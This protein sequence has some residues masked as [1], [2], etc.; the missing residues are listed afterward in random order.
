MTAK[1]NR[2]FSLVEMLVVM[3][4]IVLALGMGV[5]AFKALSGGR[6]LEAASNNVAAALGQARTYAI[7]QQ[8]T[9]GI[10]FMLDPATNRVKAVVVQDADPATVAPGSAYQ[11]VDGAAYLDVIETGDSILLP[12][13]IGLQLLDDPKEPP[14]PTDPANTVTI[15]NDRYIGFNIVYYK[16]SLTAPTYPSE[17][18][19]FSESGGGH[20]DSGVPAKVCGCILFDGQG[21]VTVRKYRL[22]LNTGTAM[23]SLHRLL[24]DDRGYDDTT[25]NLLEGRP[26][27]GL[28]DPGATPPALF[29]K[30][31]CRS[32][33]GLA[34]FDAETFSNSPT[35]EGQNAPRVYGMDDPQFTNLSYGVNE[36]AEEQWI[37]Q[38]AMVYYINRYS[39]ALVKAE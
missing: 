11:P 26:G 33:V 7:S 6:S 35:P 31:E 5:A 15:A 9:A 16:T 27:K 28:I 32:S 12:S 19:V 3:A 2:A 29:E 18:N 36:L 21:R 38:N 34:I 20:A 14:R 25:A 30:S 23:T 22:K 8:R 24:R 13:G 4:I 17:L 39:G 37:E 1:R 10:L